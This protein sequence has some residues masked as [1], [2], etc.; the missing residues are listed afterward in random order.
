MRAVANGEANPD[1]V[2]T[3][4]D[5]MNAVKGS[6]TDRRAFL[7]RI[8]P[9][10][11]L[12]MDEAHNAGGSAGNS[13]AWRV[14]DSAPPRSEVFREAVGK[15]HSVM[16][17]SA[18]Y[19]K[20]PSVMTLYSKTD[21]A[22]AVKN[23]AELPDIIKQGGVPLQQIVASMLSKAGQYI[24][25][26]R[27][28]EGV[29]YDHENIPVSDKSYSEFSSGLRAVFEFDRAFEEERGGLGHA[30][31]AEHGGGT[32]RDSGVGEASAQS[33]S[34]SAIMHNVI[35]QMI[36]AL[37]AEKAGERAVA[38]LKAG[39]KPVIAVSKTNDSF[40]KDYADE[41]G[42]KVGDVANINFSD[43]LKRYLER[44]RRVT[45]KTG[46]G[47]TVR[48]TI[49]LKDMSPHAQG[50]YR[51]AMQKLD[52]ADMGDL[53]VSPIDAMRNVLA[54]AGYSVREIT[55]RDQML[56]YSGADPVIVKRPASEV[57]A[58]GKKSTVKQFNDGKV[59][60]VILNKSGSTGIS[61]HASSKFKDQR[62]RRM[63][64][65]EADPNIDTHMQML[66]RVHRTGQVMPPAY[67]HLS[68]DIP[69][70]V[71]P[72]AVLMSKMASLNAN[73][74]GA[75]KSKF[76]ADAVDFLNHYGDEVAAHIMR[77][78]PELSDRLGNP[79]VA[80]D[81]GRPKEGAAAKVTGRLTLLD[82]QGQ[83]E[84]LDRITRDYQSVIAQ[85]D[86]AGTNDLE[87]K[88]LDLRAKTLSTRELKPA[89]GTSPFQSPVNLE[90]VSMKAQGRSY[91]P[92]E[93]ASR[94]ASEVGSENSKDLAQNLRGLAEK[95]RTK[96]DGLVSRT[97]A[98]AIE[99]L[100][101][102]V[103]TLKDPEA[104]KNATTKANEV[105]VEWREKAR[106]MHLGATVDLRM[107]EETVPAIVT[108][109][110][111]EKEA[112]N[113]TALSSW[114]VTFAL[115]TGERSL[116]APLSRIA[117]D[118]PKA[119]LSVS[120]SRTPPDELARM[121]EEARKEGREDRYMVTGNILAGFSQV[122]G[123]IVNHTMENGEVRPAILMSRS[124]NEDRFLKGRTVQFDN[125][126]HVLKYLDSP[127]LK[128]DAT[129]RS[130]DG[131]VTISKDWDGVH[132]AVPAA[133]QTGGRYYADATVRAVYDNWQKKGSTMQAVVNAPKAQEI[134]DAMM[135]TNAV[136][137]TKTNQDLAQSLADR[138]LH[139]ATDK[140]TPRER[141][142]QAYL[143]ITGGRRDE[144]V[145]FTEL[146]KKLADLDRPKVDAALRDILKR[147]ATASLAHHDDPRQLARADHDAAFNPYGEPFHGIIISSE[148]RDSGP[149]VSPA[150]ETAREP[151]GAKPTLSSVFPAY[152][153]AMAA[154]GGFSSVKISDLLRESGASKEE[155]QKLLLDEAKAGRVTIHPSTSEG[156][157]QDKALQDAAIRLP[158]KAEPY[159]NVV[160]N[161]E[162]VADLQNDEGRDLLQS[163]HGKISLRPGERSII[164]IMRT[165][166]ASTAIHELG[167][168]WLEMLKR[169]AAHPEAPQ[170]MRDMWSVAK[171]ELGV[172]VDGAISTK[173]HEKFANGYMR[174]LYEG[175]APTRALDRVFKMFREWLLPL[176]DKMKGLQVEISP[177]LRSV[178]EYM[179]STRDRDTVVTPHVEPAPEL[180]DL[181]AAEA[182]HVPAEHAGG[183]ADRIEAERPHFDDAQPPREIADEIAEAQAETA[184]GS[185]ADA[186]GETGGGDGGRG[187]MVHGGEQAGHEP[188]GSGVGGTGGPVGK[189][190]NAA[191][192]EG[193]KSAGGSGPT[194]GRPESD[195]AL[196]N[197]P[198]AP[199][200][201]PLIGAGESPFVDKAGNFKRANI[202]VPDDVWKA[203][204]DRSEAAGDNID[205]RRAP[206]TWG[207][208]ANL[209]R[210]MGKAG[211][212]A[213]VD[214]WVRGRAMNA[215]QIVGLVD[216]LQDQATEVGRL[217]RLADESPEG[218]LTFAT[219]QAR[220]D[221]V[222]KT[223]QGATAEAGR[224][225]NIFRMMQSRFKSI[226][227]MMRA[228]T[229]RTLFQ[230]TMEMKMMAAYE[231]P[232][233]IAYLTGASTKHSYGRMLLEYWIN[234]LISGP[235]THTTYMMGN[236]LLSLEKG[237]LETPVAAA[238]GALR[239]GR[240]NIVH[241]GEAA[242]RLR[243]AVSGFAPAMEAAGRA[244]STGLTGRLPGQDTMRA[245]PFQG[246]QALPLA[247]PMLNEKATMSDAKGAWFG[248]S[249]GI[250]DGMM[251]IGKILDATPAGER[252]AAPLYSPMGA[253]PDVR[254]RG[255]VLPVGQLAR[256]PSRGIAVIHTF[257]RGMNYS[258]EKSALSY[259]MAANEGKTGAALAARVAQLRL[260]TP[261]EIMTAST[262]GATDLTLMGPAGAFVRKIS[263]LTNWA[264]NIPGLGETPVLKFI[265]P[266]VHIAANIIDQSIVQRTPA[267]LLSPEIRADLMGKNGAAAQDMAQARMIVG[268]AM[269][270]GFGALAANG[271]VSGSGPTDRNKAA[272]W[273]MAG[274]QAHSV[275]IGDVWYQTNRLGPL[276]MIMGVAAD[277]YD[278][279]HLA[280]QG[281][282]LAAGAM[283]QHAI[284][285]NVLD[286]SFMRGPAELIQAVEDPG[287]YGERYIQNFA[288]SFVPYSVG[289]AQIDRASDPFSRQARTVM[290]S[291]KQKIPGLSE[292]LF[293]RRD[294]WG[295]PL[296]NHDALAAAGLTAI[297][298]QRVSRDMVNLS[299]AQLGI[300]IGP[301]DRTIRGVKL[302][303]QQYDDF[304]RLAGRMTKQRLDVI[305]NSPDWRQWPPGVRA[306][307]VKEVVTQSRE[308][309][310]GMIFM[311]FPSVY[312]E[313]TRMKAPK[314]GEAQ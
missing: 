233:S 104:K 243:G 81:D 310:C 255:G 156:A 49:P 263:E 298:E 120:R 170:K 55:G 273:R 231:T 35:S 36:M 281:D 277:M 7:R 251:S 32:A 244:A 20:S 208:T 151:A 187:E 261:D 182:E 66:G 211:S 5:Q 181:H 253:I 288:S 19:A 201:S 264:P 119:K 278:V 26:E 172:G 229:G 10:S 175:V 284:T 154:Q 220:L 34:F 100:K 302:T 85:E 56:D 176:Y 158:G 4:Y 217:T 95:G 13:E 186:G 57:G 268:T 241:F 214:G 274:N 227:E 40:I 300:G 185:I 269:S 68:A 313:A 84:L 305:V 16:Y 219:E 69:A 18:T 192:P 130:K 295:E 110:D 254:L 304:A 180:H 76:T 50:M 247:G 78:D 167:H 206:T 292:T 297:Y 31:A 89:T 155:L 294:V 303:D 48:H 118:D 107:G 152:E 285:Q 88:S 98:E 53:P 239:P 267:G 209:A 28:F 46:G 64:I 102:L 103:A 96:Q 204:K 70:E 276:G 216:M 212:E 289:L 193:G 73:T 259:R 207:Q 39:E 94:I 42:L 136:F 189:G 246:D 15:A 63:I 311:K 183:A 117:M 296:P 105:F 236:A 91:T 190:G 161:D 140:P 12:I 195:G 202:N 249:R 67:T 178:F 149:A 224:A 83:Q 301:V 286:E 280:S 11:F 271:Y 283:L 87:A 127:A 111:R 106:M 245:L 256:L 62:R 205:A 223:V 159:T 198:L 232:E 121:F 123:Q 37:K 30:L 144:F 132:F 272:I 138:K 8:A 145:R 115:P 169:D 252:T 93:V 101:N 275:K 25:R 162:T 199:R 293:P 174:W 59:D 260:D 134:I 142:E 148:T 222:L 65:A 270:L 225:L 124:F 6:E 188:A 58:G 92:D 122:S 27:S 137:E 290:D 307:V 1:V 218:V 80:D 166:N 265:D 29:S 71:R 196:G 221:M 215:E 164:T 14:R 160:F 157:F 116:N 43:I 22:K 2:F 128:E 109:F 203:I 113:P 61:L 184:A 200:P 234:G 238:L 258:M 129:V 86:A 44:T 191:A 114:N 287:R 97:Q 38:A 60:A 147:D 309:A 3:T 41:A 282:M 240:G 230:K 82:P 213:L 74:T 171:R 226:D 126:D 77:H 133:R 306:N 262:T 139:Q 131:I 248:A 23:A 135:K 33:T 237:L 279:A 150:A 308:S 90:K 9:R 177:G 52:A 112:K 125:G 168:D 153:R 165:A 173:S 210:A 143:S 99:Y 24:R 51:E 72:T 197:V 163:A 141:I 228:A 146:R 266:F 75:K 235:A 250:L 21:M 314:Y 45:I 257:L 194:S 312:A 242:A 291:I 299:L 47:E 17:S 79:S 108:S 54:K 179:H